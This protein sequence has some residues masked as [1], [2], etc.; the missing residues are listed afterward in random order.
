MM[1][2][3]ISLSILLLLSGCLPLS[4]SPTPQNISLPTEQL[5]ETLIISPPSRTPEPTLTNTPVP[6]TTATPTLLPTKDVLLQF[7][8]FGGDGG[9]LSDFYF[10]RDIP[11]LVLY[12]DGQL[13]IQKEDIGGV[14]FEETILTTPQICSLLLEVENTGFFEA[15]DSIYNFDDSTQYSD[16]GTDFI[17]QVNGKRHKTVSIYYSYVPY[18]ILEIK[19]ALN[20]ESNYSPPPNMTYY[21]PQHMLLWIEQG[22]GDSVY[23]PPDPTSQPWPAN[24][25][26]LD[27]LEKKS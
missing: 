15:E 22:L 19:R 5:I 27:I 17:I 18:L 3:I 11:T 10:G 14:W 6:P 16:G 1:T 8:V 23:L 12:S 13:L 26:S 7:G 9:S 20:L 21:Q 4:F 2:K 25:S 24:I